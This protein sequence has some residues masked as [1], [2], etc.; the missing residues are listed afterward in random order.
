MTEVR[1]CHLYP[2]HMNIYGDRGNISVLTK[3]LQWRGYPS[4]VTNVGIGDKFSPDDFD[5]CY[6]G[7]GQDKDQN[8][9]A[10][11]LAEKA[12]AIR[13]AADD[14]V[15][16]LWVCG[17]IQL[18]GKRYVDASGS[19]LLGVGILDLETIAGTERLIGDI[20][21]RSSVDGREFTV[22]GYENHIGQTYLGSDSRP[23]GKVL[24]GYGNNSFDQVEGA[25]Q[26]RV[27]GTYL[28]GPLLPKNPDL[29]DLIL[30]WAL[31]HRISESVSL[32][33]LDD[34][35]A[36]NAHKRAVSRAGLKR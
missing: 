1:I 21:I 7:G 5:L 18:A 12:P 25:V 30:T 36:V 29:A 19:E 33:K 14:G 3:R 4:S 27:I 17:G 26:Q 10:F 20:A 32:E 31:E 22:V 16:F 24:H 13:S 2:N 28:H 23:L 8:L 34:N 35:F 11:D 9:I 6:L 15:S